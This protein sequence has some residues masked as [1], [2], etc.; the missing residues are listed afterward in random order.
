MKRLKA[1]TTVLILI[2]SAQ[3]AARAQY[4]TAP[5]P[6]WHD[7]GVM[8]QQTLNGWNARDKLRQHQARQAAQRGRAP[9]GGMPANQ[10]ANN[11]TT[12]QTVAPS[13]MPQKLAQHMGKT[14][15]EQSK[16]ERE[17]SDLL[18][19]YTTLYK[20]KVLHNGEGLYDVAR[21][22]S[23]L[24][25][26]SY[27]VYNDSQPLADEQYQA[28]RTQFHDVFAT[29]P[30]F[31]RLSNREKQLLFEGYGISGL[32]IYDNY[33]DA[34]Q[35]GDQERMAHWRQMAKLNIESLLGAPPERVRLTA[36]GI[37]YR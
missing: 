1:A 14:P 25:I 36:D 27:N 28:A 10:A 30:E 5:T 34:K 19:D 29:D 17:F 15:A 2:A 22:A 35:K 12:F 26:I 11:S 13:L 23:Y 7:Y 3:M 21:A 6:S 16:L 9:G 4:S 37:E 24:F 33:Y 32:V 31:Q 18:A 20:K 8:R